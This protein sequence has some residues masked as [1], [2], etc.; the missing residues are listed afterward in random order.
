MYGVKWSVESHRMVTW[1]KSREW[2]YALNLYSL[3]VKTNVMFNVIQKHRCTTD[4]CC[5]FVPQSCK[6]K[7]TFCKFVPQSCKVNDTYYFLAE[8]QFQSSNAMEFLCTLF[9]IIRVE[10]LHGS[11]K[12]IIMHEKCERPDSNGFQLK[13]RFGTH[14]NWKN[15]NPWG[16]FWS[17]QLD[18]TAN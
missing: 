16:P 12:W 18:S 8:S 2:K 3:Q 10:V 6:L 17:Y 5:K 14:G 11:Y 13:W 15:Q 4:L 1:T 9:Q 7:L